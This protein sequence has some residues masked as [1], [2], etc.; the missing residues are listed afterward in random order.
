MQEVSS[1]FTSLLADTNEFPFMPQVFHLLNSHPRKNWSWQLRRGWPLNQW[2]SSHRGLFSETYYVVSWGLQLRSERKRSMGH[3][4]I[5]KQSLFYYFQVT[6]ECHQKASSGRSVTWALSGKNKGEVQ[7]ERAH[8]SSFYFL[9]FSFRRLF[10][11]R[12]TNWT[13]GRGY[14]GNELFGNDF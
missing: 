13:P 6:V 9:F 4:A 10:M 3:V 12:P 2:K 7:R 1:V 8:W 14:M 11:P 5:L